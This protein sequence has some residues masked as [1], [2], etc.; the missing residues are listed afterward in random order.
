MTV[1]YLTEYN[2]ESY[3]VTFQKIEFVKVRKFK[4]ISNDK[5]KILCVNPLRLFL[6][7]SEI[8]DMTAKSGA[9]DKSVFDGNTIL[10]KIIG[11]CDDKHIFIYV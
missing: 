11:K 3:G 4:G 5:N 2:T 1:V 10:L 9:F 6:G 7:K 8:F